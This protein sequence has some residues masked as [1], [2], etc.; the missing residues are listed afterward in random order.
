MVHWSAKVKGMVLGSKLAPLLAVG[1]DVELGVLWEV[2][3]EVK[4]VI[5]WACEL[6]LKL[7][8]RL[9]QTMV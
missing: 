7:E 2:E 1:S 3:M 8:Q 5:V 9:V 4:W 6:V